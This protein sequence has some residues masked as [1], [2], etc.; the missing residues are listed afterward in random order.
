MDKKNET[1][2]TYDENA[3]SMARKFNNIGVREEDLER[4]FDLVENKDSPS[5]IEI[6]CGNGREAEEILKY[7]NNY[8]G[9]DFSRGMLNLARKR[10]PEGK[11]ELVDIENYTF[12]IKIDGIVSFASLLHSNRENIGEVLKRAATGLIKGGIFY[13][14]LKKGIYNAE[15]DTKTDEFGTRTFYYYDLKMLEE[16]AIDYD[17]V[18]SSEQHLNGQ[19]WFTIALKKK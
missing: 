15:G 16:A 1:I 5:V 11:F 18:Y 3:E 2:Q 9:L 8:L 19:D 7:T 6:G 13:I 4:F 14:S 12:P 10:L 17:V